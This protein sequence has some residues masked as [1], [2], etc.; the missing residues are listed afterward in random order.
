MTTLPLRTS[1]AT[2]FAA[3]GAAPGDISP[4]VAG[5]VRLTLR[6]E[7]LALF[8]VA[9]ALFAHGGYSRGLF[10]ALFLVPDLSMLGY[11]VGSRAGAIIYNSAHS[12]LGPI[13]LGLGA[14]LVMPA[15]IPYALIWSA[16]VGFDRAL[17][18]GLK[19]Q[20]A[21]GHTHLGRIGAAATG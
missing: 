21:F 16:H 4:A 13:L 15:A 7:G 17:G 6:I 19:Y 10:A 9:I 8:A 14:V 11:L 12:L 20:T 18:Y 5:G 1:H 3:D 2:P